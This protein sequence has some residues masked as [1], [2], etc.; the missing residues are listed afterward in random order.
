LLACAL[1]T[2]NGWRE[3]RPDDKRAQGLS[4]IFRGLPLYEGAPTDPRFHPANSVNRKTGDIVTVRAEYRGVT[5][6]DSELTLKVVAYFTECA[7]EIFPAA[8]ALG[9]G[10][11][12]S[13]GL[14]RIPAQEGETAF[15]RGGQLLR[16]WA[17]YRERNE[18]LRDRKI[19]II[20]EEDTPLRCAVYAFELTA[21]YGEPGE[22]Y[23]KVRHRL[24]LHI[25]KATETQITDLARPCA[26]C[27]RT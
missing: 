23:I 15:A 9:A 17:L 10:G 6:K 12:T 3:L 8:K 26:S 27:H 13:T 19:Q 25:P 4:K 7:Y 5:T 11:M 21:A 20:L 22:G 2:V 18:P 24:P 16:A 1:V 14:A